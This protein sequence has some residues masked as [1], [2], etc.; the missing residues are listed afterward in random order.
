[1]NDV[2]EVKA[3][4]KIKAIMPWSE[5]CIHLGIAGKTMTCEVLSRGVQLYDDKGE[6]F[7]FPIL[8]GEAGFHEGT[9][10]LEPERW[11]YTNHPQS[12]VYPEVKKGDAGTDV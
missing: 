6:K 2:V 5:V 11:W 4:Q 3:G 10:D 9:V 8:H 1:M 7:S 12:E